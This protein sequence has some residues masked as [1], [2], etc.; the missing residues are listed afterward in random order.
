VSSDLSALATARNA[1]LT[2]AVARSR[3]ALGVAEAAS[4]LRVGVA[5]LRRLERRGAWPYALAE[6]AARLYDC[7]LDVFLFARGGAASAGRVP[8]LTA[9]LS[10]ETEGRA[11]R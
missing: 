9:N 6:R 11:T 8:D 1:P 7:R 10:S 5:Y 2:P 3:A 4:R